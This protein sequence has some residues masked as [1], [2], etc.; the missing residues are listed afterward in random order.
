M[1]HARK[2][3]CYWARER[4]GDTVRGEGGKGFVPIGKRRRQRSRKKSTGSGA[5]SPAR[6]RQRMDFPGQVNGKQRGGTHGFV[7]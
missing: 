4:R 3:L 6:N 2:M 7:S 5:R 1:S